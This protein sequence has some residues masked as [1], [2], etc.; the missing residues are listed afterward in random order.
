MRRPGPLRERQRRDGGSMSADH[1]AV[2]GVVPAFFRADV[3]GRA[4][5][6]TI[7]TPGSRSARIHAWPWAVGMCMMSASVKTSCEWCWARRRLPQ[8]A[9]RGS[10]RSLS[11]G[12]RAPSAEGAGPDGCGWR[13]PLLGTWAG[14]SPLGL[15]CGMELTFCLPGL[16]AGRWFRADPR[17]RAS[18]GV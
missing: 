18:V 6:K 9:G 14:V 16:W 12:T 17:P 1:S 5:E 15:W 11:V 3:G 13:C 2:V 8:G 7:V 10:A 4:T